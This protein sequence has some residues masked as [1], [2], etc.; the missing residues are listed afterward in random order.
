[1]GGCGKTQARSTVHQEAVEANVR[2]TSKRYRALLTVVLTVLSFGG[3]RAQSSLKLV[4]GFLHGSAP[5]VVVVKLV[6]AHSIAGEGFAATS[7]FGHPPATYESGTVALQAV[8]GSFGTSRFVETTTDPTGCDNLWGADKWRHVG[9]WFAGTL[10]TYLFF[11]TAFKGSKL[12][13]YLLSATVMSVVGLARE[14]SDSNSKKNCFAE[15]DLMANTIGILAAG[16]VIT[17][18]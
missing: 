14:I 9:V 17:I 8:A 4:P 13:S 10:G 16:V 2:M 15:Q 12:V 11:K 6:P 3:T 1:M 7:E 18:F 5:R